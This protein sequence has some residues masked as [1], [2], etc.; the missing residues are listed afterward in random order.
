MALDAAPTDVGKDPRDAKADAVAAVCGKSLLAAHPRR[1]VT[2]SVGSGH[3]VRVKVVSVY[4]VQ[5]RV[6]VYVGGMTLFF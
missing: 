5:V 4:R 1:L 3:R 2:V 6:C